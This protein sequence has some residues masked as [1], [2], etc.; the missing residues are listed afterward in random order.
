MDRRKSAL[1]KVYNPV[2]L[3]LQGGGGGVKFPEM[4][5]GDDRPTEIVASF[6]GTWQRK[7]FQSK[8]GV[9]T[10]L[11]VNDKK[12][13][14]LDCETLS[15]YCATCAAK[16]TKT[17]S[18]AEFEQ[19]YATQKANCSKNHDGSAGAMEPAGVKA[20]YERS[21]M[22]HALQY[23]GYLGD[24][25]SKSFSKIAAAD[26]PVYPGKSISKLE[27]CGHVQK[28]MGRR[29]N[30]AITRCKGNVYEYNL[31]SIKG[32]GGQ[33]K[34]TKKAVWR[35]QGHY[36]AAIRNNTGDLAAMKKAVCMEASWGQ[37][38]IKGIGGQG[39]LTKKAVW[40]IQGHYGAAI[41]NN[42]GDLAA[43]KKAVCMEASWGQSCR[44]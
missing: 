13:K 14:V 22:S 18:D 36:G 7:G 40:R 38:S 9:V 43:M 31:K 10:C 6:D 1:R 37:S 15:N 24:G 44:L 32:I 42:T 19:W 33:G 3:A 26:P 11:S 25:D 28:R 21:E 2:L 30:D 16:K 12:W 8:N 41:R 17:S 27:C 5:V 39:K 23:T 29:L 35:I 34:L 20:V 4:H